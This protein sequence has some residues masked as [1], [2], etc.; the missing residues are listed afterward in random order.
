MAEHRGRLIMPSFSPPENVDESLAVHRS[1]RQRLPN[2]WNAFFARFGRLR[3]I[4]MA[5]IPEILKGNNIL[6]TAPTAGGKTEAVAAPLCEQLKANRWS[7]MSVVL[8][9]PTRALVNDLFHRLEGP[10]Q[11]LGITLARKTGDHPL[12]AHGSEQFVIT[13]PESLESLLTRNRARLDQLRAIVVDEV[14]LLDGTPRGDQLRF[15]LR[16]LEIYLRYKH[17]NQAYTLQKV[18]ISAT[19]PN[20]G[21]TAA[22]YL[23]ENAAVVTVA[24]QRDIESKILLIAGDDETRA[25][26]AMLATASFTDV[27]KVLVFV[28]SRRQADLAGLYQQ[29]PFQY[30]PVYGHHGSLSKHRREETES[31]F[32]SDR[33]AVCLAT[34]TLEVGIDIGD[35]DLVI[36]MDPPFSLGSFLQRI[37]R[38]CRRLQGKTRVMC[39]A[40]D[41]ASALIFE[42]L[43]G[44]SAV[45]VPATPAA[46]IRRSVLVQQS[47]AYLRQVDKH[48]RTV[49]QCRTALTLP[50]QPVFPAEIVVDVLHAMAGQKL[51]RIQNS[52]VEPAEE[53]W[54]FIESTRI[55]NNIGSTFSDVALV[56]ADTGMQLANVRGLKTGATGVQIGGHSYEVVGSP[57]ARIRKIRATDESHPAPM[58]AARKLPY[59]A[60]VGIALARRFQVQPTEL[61]ILNLG[62]SHAAF[63][64][65]GRLQNMSLEGLLERRRVAVKASSF[66]IKFRIVKPSDCLSVLRELAS[67][68]SPENPLLDLPVEKV[69]DLGPHF[70]LLNEEQQ[71]QARGDWFQVDVLRKFVGG[72]ETHRIIDC[73]KGLGIELASLAEI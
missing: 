66:C 9:T 28:N 10:C 47:L 73:D 48:S 21:Q 51:L 36:C 32:K 2:T 68:R 3:P 37:G 6:I 49:E 39:A 16:R 43:V 55:F 5:A 17:Q 11:E 72:L 15:L 61:L 44:Q 62:D 67:E 13:T 38:G 56:D 25:R 27:R 12:P 42:A 23:G 71:R 19:V 69:V 53:G 8:V 63:T 60:D 33:R 24:G 30:A 65:L 35:V 46:P 54:S 41:R 14:H 1:I 31:R 22:A 40:R 52:V 50:V 57:S 18:A 59:A 34:M 4:Q 58:Y 64:W 7:G 45:G 70:K 29:G 26:E 20:P